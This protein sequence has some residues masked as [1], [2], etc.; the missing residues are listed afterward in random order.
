MKIFHVPV[1]IL[2]HNKF[3]GAHG[4]AKSIKKVVTVKEGQLKLVVHLFFTIGI[5]KI[6]DKTFCNVPRTITSNGN[7]SKQ[8][9][10]RDRERERM[11][12]KKKEM[13]E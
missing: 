2:Q 12:E 5:I 11:K 13:R 6:M 8:K 1:S 7:I 10:E 4:V 9:R 3:R